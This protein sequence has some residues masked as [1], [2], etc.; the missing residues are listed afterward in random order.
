LI[1]LDFS[2]EYKLGFSKE[3][4][5][6]K[7]NYIVGAVYTE[8]DST[9][10]SYKFAVVNSNFYDFKMIGKKKFNDTV[11]IDSIYSIK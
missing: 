6:D 1:G 10:Y 3:Q 9:L 2:G 5:S 11:N 8:A 4:H 7:S